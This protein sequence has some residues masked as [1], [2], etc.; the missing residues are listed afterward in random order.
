[1]TSK[2]QPNYTDFWA[3]TGKSYVPAVATDVAATIARA[4]QEQQHRAGEDPLDHS[5]WPADQ[6]PPEPLGKA[7]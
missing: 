1:M 2:K 4:R 3:R 7:Y 5:T 6:Q